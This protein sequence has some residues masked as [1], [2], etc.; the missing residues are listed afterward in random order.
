MR[1]GLAT[2]LAA[3]VLAG[4]ASVEAL[5]ATQA[6]DAIHA[7]AEDGANVLV[8]YSDAGALDGRVCEGLNRAAGVRR[9]GSTSEPTIVALPDF[10]GMTL[11]TV[12]AAPGY[13]DIVFPREP[14]MA[15]AHAVMSDA[16]QLE[17]GLASRSRIRVEGVG[18]IDVRV[19]ASRGR[20]KERT[21]WLTVISPATRTA[22]ECWVEAMPGQ[23]EAVR[24]LVAM[25]YAS[26]ADLRFSS[27][28]SKDRVA[29]AEAAWTHRP[30]GTWWL[31][32]G[33]IAGAAAA[34]MLGLRRHEYALYRLLGGSRATTL[35]AAVLESWLVILAATCASTSIVYGLALLVSPQAAAYHPLMFAQHLLAMSVAGVVAGL[36]VAFVNTG[37][38]AKILRVRR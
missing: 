35:S 17:L 21:R 5:S 22:K 33:V 19:T 1:F 10:P 14:R 23:L 38:T 18:E 25:S 37:N 28:V 20:A 7:A 29:S 15:N 31:P 26:V 2:L 16:I 8:A 27:L 4:G 36:G 34:L 9:A 24:S 30:T 6:L 32:A 11:R 3:S 12:E 13:V